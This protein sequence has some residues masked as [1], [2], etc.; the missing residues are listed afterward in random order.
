MKKPLG[1]LGRGRFK[2]F[3]LFDV[4][5]VGC[6]ISHNMIYLKGLSKIAFA[7]ALVALSNSLILQPAMEIQKKHMAAHAQEGGGDESQCCFICHPTH[8]QWMANR[9]SGSS[10]PLT[11]STS[12]QPQTFSFQPDPP[13]GSIFR[14][15]LAF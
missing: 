10:H 11:V 7:I 4:N 1:K 12:Y 2:V 13:V 3:Y 14:P 5:N 9:V 8:H 6:Y 15:P